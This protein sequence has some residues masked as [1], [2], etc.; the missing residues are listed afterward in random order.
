MAIPTTMTTGQ[1]AKMCCV[2]QRTVIRWI[3][4]GRLK[5]H[6]FPGTGGH[7]RILIS[8]LRTF[9]TSNGLPIPQE[10]EPP[11]NRVLIIE[12][13]AVIAFLIEDVLKAAGY[14]TRI[15][16]NGFVAGQLFETFK[17][18]VVT[19]D[20]KMPG[21]PGIEVIVSLRKNVKTEH[22]GILIVSGMPNNELEEA[23]AKG[24]DNAL[25]KPFRQEALLECVRQLANGIE[26]G[27]IFL[28]G[29]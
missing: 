25:A 16:A 12:D 13:E 17:P 3:D 26:F 14:E 23:I 5:G 29:S 21:I 4:S 11:K 9:L 15:A 1:A 18:D 8:D 28:E 2:S 22:V 20:L 27:E 10:L 19:L 6:R 7:R 24:A